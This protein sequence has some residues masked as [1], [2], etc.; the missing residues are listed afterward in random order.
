MSFVAS[1]FQG[2]PPETILAMGTING[3]E[4]LGCGNRFGTLHPERFGTALAI[5]VDCGHKRN[6][7]E[8]IIHHNETE[9]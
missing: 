7:I 8:T 9:I 1:N 5:P 3:A 2:I 4:A 6:I